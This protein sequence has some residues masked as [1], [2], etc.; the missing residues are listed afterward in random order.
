VR[1]RPEP[2]DPAPEKRYGVQAPASGRLGTGVQIPIVPGSA[3]EK[4][5][6][7]HLVVQQTPCAQNPVAHSAS[8]EQAAGSRPPQVAFTQGVPGAQSSAVAQAVWQAIV[9]G[10]QAYGKQGRVSRW[11]VPV[12]LQTPAPLQSV[13]EQEE[14]AAQLTPAE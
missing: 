11:Q 8:V 14:E 13:P 2:A 6:L 7:S 12:P 5:G 3:H 4:Q 1:R 9:C 10:S